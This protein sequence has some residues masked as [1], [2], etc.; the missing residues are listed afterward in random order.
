MLCFSAVLPSEN[1]KRII[2]TVPFQNTFHEHAL[3]V[4]LSSNQPQTN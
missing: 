1:P 4:L 3:H 2:L